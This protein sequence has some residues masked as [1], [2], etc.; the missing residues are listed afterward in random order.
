MI[1]VDFFAPLCFLELCTRQKMM[2]Q[3]VYIGWKFFVRENKYNIIRVTVHQ[4]RGHH[5][6]IL[7]N[8]AL[9]YP[10]FHYALLQWF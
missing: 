6:S 2:C 5:T 3:V 9:F 10:L 4:M 8:W 1:T 7:L